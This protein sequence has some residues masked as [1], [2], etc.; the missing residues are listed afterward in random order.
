M[1]WYLQN[2]IKRENWISYFSKGLKRAIKIFFR[3]T[4]L[5]SATR[6]SSAIKIVDTYRVTFYD[7]PQHPTCLAIVQAAGES[8]RIKKN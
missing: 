3:A 4:G 1:L 7:S 5:Y 2:I 6:P 8:N